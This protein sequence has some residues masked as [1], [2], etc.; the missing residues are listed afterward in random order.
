MKARSAGAILLLAA[1]LDWSHG[2]N[3]WC[4][5]HWQQRRHC[6][7]TGQAPNPARLMM[8]T[9][10]GGWPLTAALLY[11]KNINICHHI[12]TFVFYHGVLL[13]Y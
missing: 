3:G 10:V 5:P 1:Q 2:R 12:E 11:Q 6:L 8:K 4:H 9:S 13:Y 7:L